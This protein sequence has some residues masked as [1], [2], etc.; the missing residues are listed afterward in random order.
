MY[1]ELNDFGILEAKNL[2]NNSENVL[3]PV[4]KLRRIQSKKKLPKSYTE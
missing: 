1:L 4:K 3:K 2:Q